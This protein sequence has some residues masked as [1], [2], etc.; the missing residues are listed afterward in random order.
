VGGWV[1]IHFFC[2][3]PPPTPPPPPE[4]EMQNRKLPAIQPAHK[5]MPPP[6]PTYR[7][8]MPRFIFMFKHIL[9]T[10]DTQTFWNT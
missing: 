6:L 8:Y 3:V 4:K 9:Y 7:I 2:I 10:D 5:A 1:G